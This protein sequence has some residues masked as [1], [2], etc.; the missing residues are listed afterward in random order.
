MELHNPS[1]KQ[2]ANSL[3]VV[4]VILRRPLIAPMHS[5]VTEEAAVALRRYVEDG[6]T[7]IAENSFGKFTPNGIVQPHCPP[8]GLAEVFGAE[9]DEN[10]YTWPGYQ[11]SSNQPF[12]GPFS[13]EINRA[14]MIE[15]SRPIRLRF[16]PYG[17]ITPLHLTTAARIGGWNG[18][19]LASWNRFGEGE[20]FY[21]GTYL[22]LSMFHGEQDAGRAIGQILGARA[23][24][25]IRGHHLRPR[26]VRSGNDALLCVFNNSRVTTY[27]ESLVIPSEFVFAE[28]VYERRS[29]PMRY[30]RVRVRV[31]P[32]DVV[33][34]HLA[35]RQSSTG[36]C[37]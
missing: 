35:T 6:G 37:R 12:N 10:H 3:G 24:P 18:H 23:H 34:L 8:H 33:V 2:R 32:E 17:F 22:G 13:S 30:H 20:A 28:D 9:E 4:Q 11:S 26:L 14:P 25:A 1:T 36:G 21:F 29:V 19:V 15:L 16:R 7:L 27:E 31:E 5:L